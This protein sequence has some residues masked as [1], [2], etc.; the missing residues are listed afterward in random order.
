MKIPPF[1]RLLEKYSPTTRYSGGKELA[2]RCPFH[3]G[4]TQN[5]WLNLEKLVFICYRCD[6]RGSLRYLLAKVRERNATLFA[7]VSLDDLLTEKAKPQE[8]PQEHPGFEIKL[9]P[10]FDPLWGESYSGHPYRKKAIDY[11]HKRGLTN[12]LIE[13]YRIGW[14]SY[15]P[16]AWRVIVPT[17]EDQ[18]LVYWL[19]RD[20][21]NKQDLKVKNPP[22]SSNTVG[23]KEWVFNLNIAE[24]YPDIVV[25]EGVF[26]AI[27]A[28]FNAVALF[29][30]TASEIQV[31]KI[32]NKNFKTITILL[33][34]DAHREGYKLARA[35]TTSLPSKQRP[36]VR[37][38]SLP[39]GDPNSVPYQTVKETLE[40][41]TV[42]REL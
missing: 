26:D 20:F 42:V 35:F 23:A 38:A 40:R 18:R 2:I 4:A 30:K 21:T 19:A 6:E 10:G 11:L 1:V 31:K 29:G 22:K 17:Y 33:D 32:R 28:G 25:C 34:A 14:C 5:L 27:A 37:F 41:A 3:G 15:G 9:P 24:A 7:N 13:L 16:Y 8:V 39:T 36:T 12:D